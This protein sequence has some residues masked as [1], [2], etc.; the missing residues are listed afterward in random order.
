MA[1]DLLLCNP[2]FIE[3]DPVT[4]KAMDIYPLLGH[5]YLASYLDAHGYSTEI[6]DATFE[7]G[8]GSYVDALDAAKP[9]VVGVYGHLLSRD[10]AFAFA[11]AAPVRV[12]RA[13]KVWTVI[14]EG[15]CQTSNT[16]DETTSTFFDHEHAVAPLLPPSELVLQRL[17]ANVLAYVGHSAEGVP[18]FNVLCAG[19]T[20]Y[21]FIIHPQTCLAL[22][23][24]RHADSACS[25]ES[26]SPRRFQQFV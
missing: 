23:C 13:K 15:F 14:P 12:H 25:P 21:E 22:H 10:S 3:R 11:R 16:D 7:S 4:R 20:E 1:V 8:M 6:Y 17:K 5:G 2:Y 19:R 24:H 9:R 18:T 26:Q